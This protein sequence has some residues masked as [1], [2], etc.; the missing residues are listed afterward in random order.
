MPGESEYRNL[1]FRS[2]RDVAAWKE[3]CAEQR[4]I[5]L[6][7]PAYDKRMCNVEEYGWM[8]GPWS[9]RCVLEVFRPQPVW[10]ASVACFERI[11]Y[12]TIKAGEMEIEVPQD[13]LAARQT[14]VPEHVEQADFI[15]NGILGDLIRADDASQQV[16]VVDGLWARHHILKYEGARTWL[17]NQN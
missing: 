7:W 17:T 16:L 6:K 12:E 4:A 13:A 9:L 8:L 3:K 1:S 10:H 14:W 5:A 11:A 15:L 2:K